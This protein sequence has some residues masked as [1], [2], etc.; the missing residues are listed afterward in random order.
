[1]T[2]TE[3]AIVFKSHIDGSVHT[4]TPEASVQYQEALGADIIM[5]LDLCVAS[6]ADRPAVEE[7]VERTSRWAIRCRGAQARTTR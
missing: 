5:P 6:D 1:M 3:D 4:F 2:I 7:A